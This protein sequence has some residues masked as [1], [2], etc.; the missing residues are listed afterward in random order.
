M[1]HAERY[2]TFGCPHTLE[3]HLFAPLVDSRSC[4][5]VNEREQGVVKTRKRAKAKTTPPAW[6]WLETPPR[7]ASVVT[8]IGV[9]HCVSMTSTEHEATHAGDG[10]FAW[11][12]TNLGSLHGCSPLALVVCLSIVTSRGAFAFFLLPVKFPS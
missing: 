7:W 2:K 9:L 10:I 6:A 8:L 4:G 1:P 12:F 5:Q 3:S 11:S